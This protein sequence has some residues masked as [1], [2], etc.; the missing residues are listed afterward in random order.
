MG[1][2]FSADYLNVLASYKGLSD[3]FTIDV[4]GDI[5]K[6][7]AYQT[8]NMA[9]MSQMCFVIE[10]PRKHFG[11]D[12]SAG[13]AEF[14]KFYGML[15]LITGNDL[16]QADIKVLSEGDRVLGFECSGDKG[17]AKYR[18]TSLNDMILTKARWPGAD[19]D[20]K[21]Y[22]NIPKEKINARFELTKEDISEIF[23]FGDSIDSKTIKIIA[24]QG[25][26]WFVFENETTG[27]KM[28]TE[29]VDCETTSDVYLVFVLDLLKKL[30]KANYKVE[31]ALSAMSWT[32]VMPPVGEGDKA[33]PSDITARVIILANSSDR[34]N[35]E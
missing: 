33:V 4:E 19:M 34:M 35:D 9:V 24:K 2:S 7:S 22:F 11:I 18:T 27:N 6:I 26:R 30:P 17:K 3:L 25:K 29:P 23:S 1:I 32:Q 10:A 15:N 12:N 16:Q 8:N 14:L 5:V 21:I 28:E 13:F 31:A 20:G